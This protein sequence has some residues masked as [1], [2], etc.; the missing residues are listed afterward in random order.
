MPLRSCPEASWSLPRRTMKSLSSLGGR[1]SVNELLT[2][3][4]GDVDS[5]NVKESVGV[6]SGDVRQGIE[7]RH[8]AR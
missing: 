5:P 7:V 1:P 3:R 8:A 6:T 4:L 2:Q